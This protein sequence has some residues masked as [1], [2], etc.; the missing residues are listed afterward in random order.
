MVYF[1][2]QNIIIGPILVF[3]LD[4]EIPKGR[5]GK[6]HGLYLTLRSENCQLATY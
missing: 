6:I 1:P 5:D 3:K 2:D 4:S